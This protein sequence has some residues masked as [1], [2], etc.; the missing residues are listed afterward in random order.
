MAAQGAPEVHVRPYWELTF[1]A[2]G[3]PN[4][5][6]R[7]T[8]LREVRERGVR[9]LVFLAHGWNNDHDI[10]TRLYDRFFAPFPSLA[11]HAHLGYVGVVW[12]SMR[13]TDETIPNFDPSAA[14]APA[15]APGVS[16]DAATRRALGATFPGNEPLIDRITGLLDRQPPDSFDEFGGLVRQLTGVRSDGIAADTVEELSAHSAL[17]MFQKDTRTVCLQFADALAATAHDVASFTLPGGVTRAWHGARELLRQAT[18]FA[19]KKRAGTVGQKGLG[20]ALGRLA[21]E[22]KDVRVH[23]VGHSFGARLVSFALAGLPA[24]TRNVKSVTL[25]EGA[26]SHYAFA[27]RGVLNGR[28]SRIDGPLVSCYSSFDTAL[29]VLYPMASRLSDDDRGLVDLG[30]RWGAT[31]HDGILEV[32]G[33]VRKSLAEVLRGGVPGTGCVSVDAAQVV[34]NGPPPSGAHSDICHEELARVVLSA[35]RVG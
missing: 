15:P 21:T 34:R 24:G 25:L 22:A 19:M 31:G 9:D 10:A 16:L 23:L 18:Y 5:A 8:L 35:G 20:P 14:A 26:F 28:Q 7:D 2:D 17:T 29:S 4:P 13:F 27:R 12:P 1:D 11:P 6:Q 3:D 32:D 30:V 33:A